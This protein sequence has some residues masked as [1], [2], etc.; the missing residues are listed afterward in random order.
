[1]DAKLKH[2]SETLSAHQD[3]YILIGGNA[4]WTR[5]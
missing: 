1:M 2:F 4:L 3:K 5:I